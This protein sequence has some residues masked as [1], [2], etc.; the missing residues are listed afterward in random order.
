VSG[1]K[2]ILAYQGRSTPGVLYN[3]CKELGL[4]YVKVNKPM[5]SAEFA[6]AKGNPFIVGGITPTGDEQLG[7]DMAKSFLDAGARKIVIAAG[8]KDMGNIQHAERTAGAY[9]AIAEFEAGN[10]GVKIDVSEFGG[11]P[12]DA[13][14][15]AQAKAIASN[16][17]AVV[18]TFAG[19]D[20]W[21]QPLADAGKAGKI[22]LGSVSSIN[23]VSAQAMADGTL[24]WLGALYP[25]MAGTPFAL[26][27][28]WMTGYSAD[29]SDNGGAIFISQHWV[30]ITTPEEMATWRDIVEADVPAYTA[31]DLKAVCKAFN[32]DATLDEF[33][34]LVQADALEDIIAR[35]AADK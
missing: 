24:N 11:Y 30:E 32:P 29:F 22:M 10:P 15:A 18:A 31:D 16:P 9:R 8:G 1:V 6:N 21:L 2:G 20:L 26:L 14:F 7:Y 25:Q 3:K 28:N 12:G 17:D 19:E 13:F 35:R 34:A 27:Y 5:G 33:K 4:F 23:E